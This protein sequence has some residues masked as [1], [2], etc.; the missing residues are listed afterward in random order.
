MSF[1]VLNKTPFTLAQIDRSKED[2]C[3]KDRS[4]CSVNGLDR[5]NIDLIKSSSR[6]RLKKIDLICI[7]LT[8][9]VNA[10]DRSRSN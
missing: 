1:K 3:K 8:L 6:G 4:L 2:R 10:Q 5:S 9:S 7:D